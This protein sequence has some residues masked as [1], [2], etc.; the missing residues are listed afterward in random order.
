[1]TGTDITWIHFRS[2]RHFGTPY[3]PRI[4]ALLFVPNLA[5]SLLL[6]THCSTF[7]YCHTSAIGTLPPL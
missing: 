7:C 1:V 2:W 3:V 4:L 5:P 6:A